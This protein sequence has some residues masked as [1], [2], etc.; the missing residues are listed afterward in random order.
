MGLGN[1]GLLKSLGTYYVWGCQVAGAGTEGT[2]D[3]Q[4]SA[5]SVATPGQSRAWFWMKDQDTGGKVS[6][7]LGPPSGTDLAGGVGRGLG[8]ANHSLWEEVSRLSVG[9]VSLRQTPHL[10]NS[11]PSSRRDV[12]N[13]PP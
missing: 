10:S 7:D 11:F 5:L 4:S 8:K 6:S 3:A 1:T 9:C 13:S 12:V 2:Q